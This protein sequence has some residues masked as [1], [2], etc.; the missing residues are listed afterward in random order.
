M[1][2]SQESRRYLWH[3][4]AGL[5]GPS[6]NAQK[7]SCWKLINALQIT[8]LKL[9]LIET[10]QRWTP[11]ISISP[12]CFCKLSLGTSSSKH[13]DAS[14]S[15]RLRGQTLAVALGRCP[16]PWAARDGANSTCQSL[17]HLTGGGNSSE[18]VPHQTKAWWHPPTKS[19]LA[20][21]CRVV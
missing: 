16:S 21:P 4:M 17:P 8:V 14:A 13:F 5:N 2:Q 1:S 7:P 18:L 20:I 15:T 19:S 6:K 3:W 11:W 12:S 10:Q 9:S